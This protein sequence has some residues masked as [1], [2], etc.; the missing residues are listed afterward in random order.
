MHAL[1][2]GEVER[3]MTH[4]RPDFF[5]SHSGV[6]IRRPAHI[7]NPAVMLFGLPRWQ[8]LLKSLPQ[9]H[10]PNVAARTRTVSAVEFWPIPQKTAATRADSD[11]DG[12]R[13]SSPITPATQSSLPWLLSGAVMRRERGESALI[14]ET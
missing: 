5:L 1:F 4:V 12:F 6:R 2:K 11:P 13:G 8:R 9:L 10:I 14:R 3:K 7:E